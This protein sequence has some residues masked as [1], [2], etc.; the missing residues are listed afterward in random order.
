MKKFIA[1]LSLVA[2]PLIL[3]AQAKKPTL[4]VVPGDAWCA[5]NGY[6][7]EFNSQGKVTRVPDYER[8]LVED[9]SM[10]L[11]RSTNSWPTAVLLSR[12]SRNR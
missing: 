1:I 11:P 7:T 8:A 9:M 6:M 4:I 3:S 12:I 5:A 2:L 10:S